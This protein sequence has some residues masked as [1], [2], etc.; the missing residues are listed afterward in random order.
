LVLVL[1]FQPVTLFAAGFSAGCAFI[2]VLTHMAKFI[3]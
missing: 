1:P 3:E 2:E